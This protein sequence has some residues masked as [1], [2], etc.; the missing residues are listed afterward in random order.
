MGVFPRVHQRGLKLTS[1]VVVKVAGE[2][3]TCQMGEVT[4]ALSPSRDW[5]NSELRPI[6]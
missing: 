2:L 5:G 6:L 4:L 1:P 3:L